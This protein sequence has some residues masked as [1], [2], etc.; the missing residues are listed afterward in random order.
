[1]DRAASA[2]LCRGHRGVAH[3]VSAPPDLGGGH[4]TRLR[5]AA[6]SSGR[7]CFRHHHAAGLGFSP[8]AEDMQR[9]TKLIGWLL[10]ALWTFFPILSAL[11]ASALASA[12]ACQ[13]DA[14]GTHPCMAFGTD[15]GES[16]YTLFVMAWF[17]FFT[18]PS[19]LV[20]AVI[21]LV[22]VLVFGRA[23]REE[24]RD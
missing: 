17:A 8:G 23:K 18:I 14:G 16:L 22:L 11:I 5:R 6:A 9:K 10:I 19:G 7:R 21:F 20:A 15:I 13:L 12:F 2:P 1:M 4:R 24:K 3:L